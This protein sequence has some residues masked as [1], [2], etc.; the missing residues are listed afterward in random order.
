MDAHERRALPEGCEWKIQLVDARLFD[1]P[2]TNIGINAPK[3]MFSENEL[4]DFINICGVL[5]K[6]IYAEG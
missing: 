2:F 1:A 6:E 5:Q 3:P 4:N